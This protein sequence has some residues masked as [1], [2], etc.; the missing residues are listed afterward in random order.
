MPIAM[1]RPSSLPPPA[2][3][4]LVWSIA[5][6]HILAYIYKGISDS[7]RAH[8]DPASPESTAPHEHH[9]THHCRHYSSSMQFMRHSKR[10][11]ISR[12]PPVG[13]SAGISTGIRQNIA[14]IPLILSRY[15]S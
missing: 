4:F 13:F 1:L 2:N 14:H 3:R 11:R 8:K 7:I 6:P 5:I 9:P 15:A 10:L 12:L